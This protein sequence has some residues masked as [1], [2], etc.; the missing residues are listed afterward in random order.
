MIRLPIYAGAAVVAAIVAAA[1]GGY[2]SPSSTYGPSGTGA[3]TTVTIGT[4]NSKLGRIL[5]DS[6]GETLYLFEA[7]NGTMS[8]CNGSC[9]QAWPPVTTSGSPLPGSGATAAELATTKR[10]DGTTQVLYHGHPLY[11]YAGDTKAGDTTGQGLDQ[12]GGKWY[13]LAPSGN[14]IVNG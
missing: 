1:C 12:F 11:R 13:V 6:N 9:A 5:V 2:G 8:T 3:A 10:Q 14:E 4:G 7:D